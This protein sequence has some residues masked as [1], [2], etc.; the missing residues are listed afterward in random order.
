MFKLSELRRCLLVLIAASFVTLDAAAQ[1]RGASG[2]LPWDSP[3]EQFGASLTGPVARWG[4]MIAIVASGLSLAFSDGNAIWRKVV[5]VVFGGSIAFGAAA[6][7]ST[8]GG[9]T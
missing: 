1:S 4:I 8:L 3:M 5:F 9:T 2:P 6:L 7:V